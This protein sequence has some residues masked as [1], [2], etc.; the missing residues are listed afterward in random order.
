MP[1]AWPS[2]LK[3]KLVRARESLGAEL[4]TT[5][6]FLCHGI[7]GII[8]AGPWDPACH[9]HMSVYLCVSPLPT[10]N[11]CSEGFLLEVWVFW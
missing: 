3:W 9:H 7:G 5:C 8:D 1:E 6:D 10:G 2:L 11:R 4:A